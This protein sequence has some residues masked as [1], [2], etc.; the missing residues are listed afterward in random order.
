VSKDINMKPYTVLTV[1]NPK[2]RQKA[3]PIA[4]V[5][6]EIR[7]IFERMIV[8]MNVEDGVGLAATQVGIDKRLIVMNIEDDNHNHDHD[9]GCCGHHHGTVYRLAN[10]E[11]IEKSS[12]MQTLTDGCLSVPDQYAEVSRAHSVKILYL[13][14]NNDSQTLEADGLLAFCIQ[15][16][17]DHLNGILFTDHL[18]AVRRKLIIQRAMKVIARYEKEQRNA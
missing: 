9:G 6:D 3:A 4:E 13:D 11:I 2:L 18:S 12:E 14:E 10:P 15:H 5:N 1:P 8:T 17:I 16:E 7:T